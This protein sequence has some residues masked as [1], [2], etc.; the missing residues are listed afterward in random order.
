MRCAGA[1]EVFNPG[2]C[3]WFSSGGTGHLV[4]MKVVCRWRKAG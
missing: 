2:I 1:V 4:L 3:V